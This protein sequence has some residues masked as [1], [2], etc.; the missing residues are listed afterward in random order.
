MMQQWSVNRMGSPSPNVRAVLA[1]E[2]EQ[3]ASRSSEPLS[4]AVQTRRPHR[5]DPA[6]DR[7]DERD[8]PGARGPRLGAGHDPRPGVGHALPIDPRADAGTRVNE[9]LTQVADQRVEKDQASG[10]PILTDGRGSA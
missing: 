7:R 1:P 10:P 2:D 8:L 4:A 9:F 3:P 5:A 6:P